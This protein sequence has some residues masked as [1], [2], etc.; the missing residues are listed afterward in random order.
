LDKEIG[1]PLT[2]SFHDLIDGILPENSIVNESLAMYNDDI[3]I[4]LGL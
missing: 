4:T 3:K 1:Q 2:N